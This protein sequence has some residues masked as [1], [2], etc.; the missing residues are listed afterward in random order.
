M[1]SSI[2]FGSGNAGPIVINTSGPVMIDGSGRP[3]A[4]TGIA[5]QTD[6][7]GTGNAGNI[8]I[9]AGS[10]SLANSGAIS[11]TTFG[12]G[13]GGNI[14]IGVAGSLL[15]DGSGSPAQPTGIL[16]VANDKGDAGSITLSAVSLTVQPLG[17]ITT[18][19]AGAGKAGSITVDVTGAV[20]LTGSNQVLGLSTGI[21]SDAVRGS[22]G[23][24]GQIT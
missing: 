24:A 2:T 21:Q 14:N 3:A 10:M 1:I 11:T 6:V 16:S 23:D 12:A 8:T 13:L 4:L 18:S 7:A 9:N 19:T 15:I 17:R 22:T 20:I 5:S